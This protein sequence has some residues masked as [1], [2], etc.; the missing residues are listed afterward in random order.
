[1]ALSSD[2]FFYYFGDVTQYGYEYATD[3]GGHYIG[4]NDYWDEKQE[5]IMIN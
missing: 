3:Y 2:Y 5:C 4:K 1:M